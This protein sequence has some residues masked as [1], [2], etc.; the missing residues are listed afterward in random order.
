[1]GGKLLD[2]ILVRLLTPDDAPTE[3]KGISRVPEFVGKER[4]YRY[5][6]YEVYQKIGTL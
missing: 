4:R 1:M 3:H 2:K 5:Y 6:T